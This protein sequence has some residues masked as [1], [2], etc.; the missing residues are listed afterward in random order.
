[1][2]LETPFQS[3]QMRKVTRI[4]FVGIGGAGMG[5]I[6]E[7][8]LNEGYQVAGSDIQAGAMTQRLTALGAD[9]AIGHKAENVEGA[10]VV[11]VSSAINEANPEIQ[12]ARQQRI[13]IIRRAEMLAELMRFRH[14]I[15]VAGTHGK[16]TTTSLIATIFGEAETDPTFVIG[17]LLNSA[18]T[19]ARLGKSRY[20]IAEADESDASFLH[21]QPMMSVVT[22]I[23]AD[24]MDTYD[25]D[26]SKMTDTYIEF[27]HNLPFYG[28][29]VVCGDDPVIRDLLPRIGRSVLTYGFNDDND[30]RATNIQY[31]FG[32]TTFDVIR[33]GREPLA[34]ELKLSGA[35]NVLNALAAITVATEEDIEDSAICRALS[36][37]GGI[38]RRFEV[39]GEFSTSVGEVTLVDDY[40]HHPTEVAATIAAARNNWPSQRLVMVYQPH[41]FSR[42]RDLYEDFVEV[43]SQVDCLLLLDVYAASEQPIEGADS[44]A[45]AR[46]IRARGQLEP[47]YVGSHEELPS[48]LANQLQNGD[49]VMTQGAGNIGQLAKKLAAT[50]MEPE[51][52]QGQLS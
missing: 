6:A 16:T 29:A 20:L 50:G 36:T 51:K 14:G 11:V 13:P 34:I 21:L 26:F 2:V 9:I 4:F 38:G 15:A 37:F 49:I 41:R 18:G 27:L 17:G 48:I 24:H 3:P 40:G 8:L 47:V 22:N 35:H 7:V 52:L 25:G 39:L 43:L 46:S 10:N 28:Q 12:F 1:M 30:V 5:G 31:Q 45:L 32:R 19:N 23:E 44:R 42:T 33:P